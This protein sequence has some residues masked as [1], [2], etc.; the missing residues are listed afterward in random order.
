M[1]QWIK[2]QFVFLQVSFCVSGIGM[3]MG[4]ESLLGFC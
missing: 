4:Y 2:I 1:L 3:E